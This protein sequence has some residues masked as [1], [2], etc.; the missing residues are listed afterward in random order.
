MN[1]KH[2]HIAGTAKKTVTKREGP[3]ALTLDYTYQDIMKRS[4]SNSRHRNIVPNYPHTDSLNSN[5]GV[6]D[7]QG[8]PRDMIHRK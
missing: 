8:N 3:P 5:P 6:R 7:T 4:G 2:T 1:E